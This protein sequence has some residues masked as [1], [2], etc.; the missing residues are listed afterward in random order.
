[1]AFEAMALVDALQGASERC[2]RLL[3]AAEGLREVTGSPPPLPSFPIVGA[4]VGAMRSA[5]PSHEIERLWTA[6]RATTS[7]EALAY[8]LGEIY[9]RVE[10]SSA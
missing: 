1:L 5:L 4:A 10:L 7:S 8:A 2:A 3:G 9:H 6:G